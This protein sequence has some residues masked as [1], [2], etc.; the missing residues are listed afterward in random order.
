VEARRGELEAFLRALAP[1]LGA[2]PGAGGAAPADRFGSV[3]GAF[4]QP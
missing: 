1:L 4:L 3:L 2:A